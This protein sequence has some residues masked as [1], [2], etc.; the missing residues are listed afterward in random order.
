M[1]HSLDKD[2]HG[3]TAQQAL[4]RRE[5]ERV[6]SQVIDGVVVTADAPDTPAP[7]GPSPFDIPA[8]VGPPPA[9]TPAPAELSLT[10]T[11]A[12]TGPSL[13]VPLDFPSPS[14]TTPQRPRD[15]V[16]AEGSSHMPPP[17]DVVGALLLLLL[18]FRLKR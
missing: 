9:V 16:D 11:P 13:S 18:R 5:R 14:T 7:V 1:A 15:D 4:V 10:V 17:A 3:R 2:I 6:V 12:P 8:P